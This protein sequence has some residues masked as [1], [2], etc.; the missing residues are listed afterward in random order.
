MRVLVTGG[1]GFIGSHVVDALLAQS[2]QVWV[3]DNLEGGRAE[4]VPPPAQL[5][6]GDIRHPEEWADHVPKVDGV[7]HL[8]AQVSVPHGEEDPVDDGSTNVLGTLKLL[9]WAKQMEVREFR[10]ASSAAVYGVPMALPLKESAPLAPLAFYGMHKQAGEWDVRHFCEING[11]IGVALRLANVYGPR[12]RNEGEGAVVAA[13]SHALATD[14]PAVL[15]GDGGQ[16]RDFIFVED[17]ARAFTTS[18][19]Q[20][21]RGYT[22]NIGTAKATTILQ[23]WQRLARLAGKDPSQVRFAPARQG[24]IRH[25]LLAVDEA[26]ACLGFRAEVSLEE[27][28]RKTYSYLSVAQQ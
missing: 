16:S 1:A 12:Q 10:F 24:D 18:L 14:R 21:E 19:G 8:A 27:G 11:M 26:E 3:L 22:L 9:Q 20:L 23:L 25:S 6:V 7:L 5:V 28:L 2:H 15:H 13:F 17:V 4:L